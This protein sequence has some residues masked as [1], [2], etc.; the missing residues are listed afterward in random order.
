MFGVWQSGYGEAMRRSALAV[1]ALGAMAF[2]ASPAGAATPPPPN[3]LVVEAFEEWYALLGREP[4]SFPAC[5]SLPFGSQL[6][7]VCYGLTPG[8]VPVV[9]S[10]TSIGGLPP[11]DFFILGER[12]TLS[13]LPP[14][15][16][17]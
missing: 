12:P 6:R 13:T 4:I 1:G 15:P 17:S 2:G 10:G 7:V 5:A 16:Q 8:L 9:A 3:D 11:L 14:A